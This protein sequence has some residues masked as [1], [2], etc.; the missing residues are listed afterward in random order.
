VIRVERTISLLREALIGRLH[1]QQ[2]VESVGADGHVRTAGDEWRAGHVLVCAGH[3]TPRLAAQAGLEMRCALFRHVRFSFAARA[4]DPLACLI[5]ESVY[6][7]PVGRTG[8][9][10]VGLHRAEDQLDA[11]T[12]W[13]QAVEIL[14]ARTAAYV[15]ATLPGLDAEAGREVRCDVPVL[16]AV[17]VTGGDGWAVAQTSRVTALTGANLMK[18]VPLLGARLADAAQTGTVPGALT[19]CLDL[20]AAARS[21][22]RGRGSRH[23]DDARQCHGGGDPLHRDG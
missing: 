5:D 19:P 17:G 2:R 18:F 4:P 21:D 8:D 13:P 1:T 16:D 23:D 10:A 12:P 7:L 20:R 11:A 15:R 3:D 9:Y 22:V 6:G 14:R